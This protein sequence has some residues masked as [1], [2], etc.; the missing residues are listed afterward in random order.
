MDGA[1]NYSMKWEMASP[2]PAP[3]YARQRLDREDTTGIAAA[4]D[5]VLRLGAQGSDALQKDHLVELQR[6]SAARCTPEFRFLRE[7][8]RPGGI[9]FIPARFGLKDS[10]AQHERE[11]CELSWGPSTMISSMPR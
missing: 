1:A 9:S 11:R 2:E 8:R 7:R 5:A 6:L 3:W 10:A 4:L